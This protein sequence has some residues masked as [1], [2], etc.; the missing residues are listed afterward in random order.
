M[1]STGFALAAESLFKQPGLIWV[2]LD[3]RQGNHTGYRSEVNSDVFLEVFSQDLA[4]VSI[5]SLRQRAVVPPHEEQVQSDW[6]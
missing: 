3:L 5:D 6:F 2:I 1:V 4:T